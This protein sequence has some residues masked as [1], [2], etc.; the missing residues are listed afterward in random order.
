MKTYKIV[1][2]DALG[3]MTLFHSVSRSRR[4]PVGEWLEAD[5]KPARDGSGDRWYLAGWHS[6]PTKA[7]AEAYLSRFRVDRPLSVVEVEVLDTWTKDHSPNSI[8]LSRW[9]KV[10]GGK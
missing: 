4:L 9:L 1:E 5:V 10:N 3:Y 6:L 8:I 2:A 7:E